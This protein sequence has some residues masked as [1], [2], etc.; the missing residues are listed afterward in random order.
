MTRPT[1]ADAIADRAARSVAVPHRLRRTDHPDI[2]DVMT[3]DGL[4][5]LGHVGRRVLDSGRVAWVPV[6]LG[7]RMLGFART[8]LDA[9]R[10]VARTERAA[11]VARAHEARKVTVRQYGGL[12]SCKAWYLHGAAVADLPRAE[13]PGRFRTRR[14]AREWAER[15]G[16]LVVAR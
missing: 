13:Q 1:I 6:D 8:K 12:P 14:D 4:A 9:G 3:L 10:E 15:A 5:R 11:E 2:T 7:D 16:M